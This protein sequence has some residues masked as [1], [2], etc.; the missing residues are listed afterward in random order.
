MNYLTGAYAGIQALIQ[1]NKNLEKK[2]TDRVT[3]I[4]ELEMKMNLVMNQLN[5]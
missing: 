3:K 1:K 5:L 2:N 4:Y